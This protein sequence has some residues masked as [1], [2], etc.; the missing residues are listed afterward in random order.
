MKYTDR[1]KTPLKWHYFLTYIGIPLTL[2]MELYS[3]TSFISELFGLQIPY[4]NILL[5]P[6]LEVYGA[7]VSNLGGCFWYVVA[8]FLISVM[9]TV[10]LLLVCIGFF[11][12]K[13]SA[14]KEWTWYLLIQTVVNAAIVYGA[15]VLYSQ[16]AEKFGAL[17]ENM[18]TYNGAAKV[19]IGSGIILC[20][21]I[22]GLIFS[23]LML[24]MNIIYYNRRKPLFAVTYLPQE[25]IPAAAADI[26]AE[27]AAPMQPSIPA[28]ESQPIEIQPVKEPSVPEPVDAVPAELQPQ[29][30][31]S[32]EAETTAAEQSVPVFERVEESVAPEVASAVEEKQEAPA[33]EDIMHFCP[34]CGSAL[35]ENDKAFCTHCGAKLK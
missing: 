6:V 23:L 31:S 5:K 2:L 24:I 33:E 10:L 27:P 25:N 32:S 18:L 26:P 9:S 13:D 15:F 28:A 17:F 20:I 8:Y 16:S 11:T 12:W 19:T 4:T 22:T 1:K 7:T 29:D 35:N 30:T 21:M 14:R 3:L 34:N